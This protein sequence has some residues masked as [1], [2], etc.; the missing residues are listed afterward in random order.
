MNATL[1]WEKAVNSNGHRRILGSP[2]WG[3][4][5]RAPM[6][7]LFPIIISGEQ[8]DT[9]SGALGDCDD[10]GRHSS[11]LSAPIRPSARIRFIWE[12]SSGWLDGWMV[13]WEG[14]RGSNR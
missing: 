11:S 14:T 9:I 13:D 3:N 5:T 7:T 1:G 10:Y 4:Y 12:G 6:P 8:S 2:A